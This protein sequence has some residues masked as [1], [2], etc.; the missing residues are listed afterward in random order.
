MTEVQVSSIVFA[1]LSLVAGMCGG[2]V[3]FSSLRLNTGLFARGKPLRALAMQLLRFMLLVS[4]LAG[5]AKLGPGCLLAGALGLVAVRG[6]V[7]R[8]FGRMP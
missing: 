8:R 2:A 6:P 4:L 1:C 5:L 3:H 7:L